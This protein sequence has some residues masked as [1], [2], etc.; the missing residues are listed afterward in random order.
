MT[1]RLGANK[2]ARCPIPEGLIGPVM[3]RGRKMQFRV[4]DHAARVARKSFL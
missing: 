3:A 4:A 1:G 2:F